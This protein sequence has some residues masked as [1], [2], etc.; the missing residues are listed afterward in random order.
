MEAPHT[1]NSNTEVPVFSILQ[2]NR[3]YGKNRIDPVSEVILQSKDHRSSNVCSRILG[4]GGGF[5]PSADCRKYIS[6]TTLTSPVFRKSSGSTSRAKNKV[7]GTCSFEETLT[8]WSQ[9][10]IRPV[11]YFIRKVLEDVLGLENHL[12]SS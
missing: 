12:R 6:K 1:E 8:F 9:C 5:K 3:K 2:F 7:A 11:G 4:E 10:W